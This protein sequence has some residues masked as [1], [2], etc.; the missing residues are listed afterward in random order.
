M[1]GDATDVLRVTA[2]LV[3]L[4]A[5]VSVMVALYNTMNERRREI[6]IMRSLGARRQQIL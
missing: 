1:V 3:L 6:A 4:V 2:F 5:G